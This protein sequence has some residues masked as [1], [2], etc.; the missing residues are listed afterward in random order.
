MQKRKNNSNSENLKGGGDEIRKINN[1]KKTI[2]LKI[3]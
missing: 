2:E 3:I 1:K